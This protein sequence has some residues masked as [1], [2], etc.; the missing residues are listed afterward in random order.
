MNHTEGPPKGLERHWPLVRV[1][2]LAKLRGVK[3]EGLA[4]FLK[5][6]DKDCN[7]KL[8]TKFGNASSPLY[9]NVLVL[10]TLGPSEKQRER[11]IQ[12]LKVRVGELE[13][14]QRRCDLR[15]HK[16]GTT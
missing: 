2:E 6:L 8:L 4:K 3:T 10:N 13:T 1:T 9:V 5:R 11:D 16:T 7:G 12:D 15:W 14:K